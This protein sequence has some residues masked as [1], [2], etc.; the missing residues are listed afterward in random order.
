MKRT[1]AGILAATMMFGMLA[2]CGG[3]KPTGDSTAAKPE[4]GAAAAEPTVRILTNDTGGKDE[5]E[6]KLFQEELSK[7]SGLNVVLE[8]PPSDYEK[9]VAQKLQ[10]G[11]EYDLIYFTMIQYPEFVKQG[12]LTDVT[13]KVKASSVFSG[14][15]NQQEWDDITIDGKIYA[16]FNKQEVERCVLFNQVQLKAAGIDYQSIEP[17]LDGYYNVFKKLREMNAA[18]DYYPLNIVLSE[19]YDLQPWFAQ[20]GIK[21]GITVQDGKRIVPISQDDAAPVWEWL[22]KLYAEKLLDPS[23][24]V[25]K[26]KDMRAKITADKTTCNVDW[27]AF[28]GIHND[29]ALGAGR[30][31]DDFQIVSLPGTKTPDGSYLLVKGSAS[32]WGIPVNAKNPEGAFQLMEF[33]ATQEGGEVLS[34]GIEGHDYT[35][36]ADGSYKL[37]EIGVAHGKDHGAPVPIDKNFEFKAGINP[38][39][40][41]ALSYMQYASIEMP[42]AK[43]ADFKTI[44]GKWGVQIVKGDVSVMD[45]LAKMRDELKSVGVTD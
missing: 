17:T 9:V 36:E 24:A 18:P 42:D 20:Y 7:R 32:L 22:K 10:G 6:M 38:G 14:N 27:A 1:L 26:T 28:A 34:M 21:S 12:V 30:S 3:E 43:H 35:V 39:L 45:G 19:S 13:E 2:G 8:K 40:E 41:E 29:D 4:S 15:V 16:G 5:A 23:C 11:E 31:M 44:C 37:T 33:F 25:D